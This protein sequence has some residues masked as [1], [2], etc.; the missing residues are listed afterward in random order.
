MARP[1]KTSIEKQTRRV[2]LSLTPGEYERVRTAL[3]MTPIA[4]WIRDVAL[5]NLPTTRKAA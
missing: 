4:T 3:G 2:V 1:R 5:R